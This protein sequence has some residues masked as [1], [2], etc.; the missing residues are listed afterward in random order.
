LFSRIAAVTQQAEYYSG[1]YRRAAA[2]VESN[3]S[4]SPKSLEQALSN[5]AIALSNAYD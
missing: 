3:G 2:A 1:E 4:I 5:N